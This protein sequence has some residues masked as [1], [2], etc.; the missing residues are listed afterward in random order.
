MAFYVLE[1]QGWAAGFAS[2]R[3][4]HAIRDLCDF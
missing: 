4:A 2:F 1:E 3:F